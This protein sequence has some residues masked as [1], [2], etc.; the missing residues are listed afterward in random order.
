MSI[1][2]YFMARFYDS[3]MKEIES[4]CFSDWRSEL[5]SDV[6]GD[7]LE[8]GSGTGVNLVHYP[9]SIN[10]LVLTEP[11]KHMLRLL[12]QTIKQGQA[13]KISVANT[14]AENFSADNLEFPD[15]SFD[16]VV[17][18]LV[19]CS[20]SSQAATLSEIRRV[21]KPEGKLYFLE[22]VVATDR[23][24]L[25]K[26]QRLIQPFW[27]HMCGNC[28]LTRDTESSITRAGFIFEKIDRPYSTGGPPIVSPT[29]K[30]IARLIY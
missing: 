11:D 30:G 13:N 17:S 22:H 12:N 14:R 21:L 18:T 28:H 6:R 27:R 16:S 29:I 7:V 20:V 1:R 15:N 4:L 3:S 23:P 2:S 5:L 19:L 25:I 8:I 24:R 10:S 9:D 26:W